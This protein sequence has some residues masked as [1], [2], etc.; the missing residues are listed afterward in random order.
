MSQLVTLAEK[1]KGLG[2]VL[3]FHVDRETL[4]RQVI[5][6]QTGSLQKKISELVQNAHDAGATTV[7]ITVTT[8]TVNVRDNGKGFG[9]KPK[10]IAN[11]GVFGQT[12]TRGDSDFGHFGLGRGQIMSA[13]VNVW[14]TGTFQMEVDYKKSITYR[15][16]DGLPPVA[17]CHV[18]VRL[19][20]KLSLM[21]LSVLQ[22]EMQQRFEYFPIVVVYN[23]KRIS[24]DPDKE[25]WT[26]VLP[27]AYIRF[28]EQGSLVVRNMGDFTCEIPAF[29]FGIGG[30]IVSRVPLRLNIARD[31]WQEDC[32]IRKKIMGLVR[33][34]ATAN[35]L[36]KETL[37]EDARANLAM[38]AAAGALAPGAAWNL[39]LITAVTGRQLAISTLFQGTYK[40]NRTVS[41]APRGNRLGDKLM[42]NSVALIIADETLTRFGVTTVPELLKLTAKLRGTAVPAHSFPRY[43]PFEQLTHTINSQY[44]ILD[45]TAWTPTEKLWMELAAKGGAEMVVGSCEQTDREGQGCTTHYRP[46]AKYEKSARRLCIGVGPADGWTDGVNYVAINRDFLKELS[47]DVRG[48][49]KLGNLLL[50]EACHA[51]CDAKTHDHDQD[52]YEQFH[53]HVDKAIV[54]FVARILSLLP[55]LVERNTFRLNKRALKALDHADKGIRKAAALAARS[56]GDES[57]VREL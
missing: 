18:A 56:T 4:I 15:L 57:S 30:V 36:R 46:Y 41:N 35:N 28:S 45:A 42:R 55:Q 43:V 2:E 24:K 10:L 3:D 8:T 22:R 33:T 34:E 40:Y 49:I 19:Y 48:F 39:K 17:G 29:R 52:F 5:E 21:D 37:T 47:L 31:Q 20:E 9:T 1:P 12:K 16:K 51:G 44:Q 27:E 11:F 38:Q 23:T 26:H 25:K 53:D 7:E 14:R 6:R 32:P 50:H 54:P 13:G